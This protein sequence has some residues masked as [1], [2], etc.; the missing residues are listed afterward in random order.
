MH[1]I[2]CPLSQSLSK[3]TCY[4]KPEILA[5]FNMSKLT[6]LNASE[7]DRYRLIHS[8]V[9]VFKGHRTDWEPCTP[10]ALIELFRVSSRI[11]DHFGEDGEIHQLLTHLGQI[12]WSL[13]ERGYKSYIVT[14]LW[15]P[16]SSIFHSD[17]NNKAHSLCF[18]WCCTAFKEKKP[19]IKQLQLTHCKNWQFQIG[20]DFRFRFRC[21]L[22]IGMQWK[23][24]NYFHNS[25]KK[26]LYRAFHS[27]NFHLPSLFYTTVS[28]CYLEKMQNNKLVCCFSTSIPLNFLRFLYFKGKCTKPRP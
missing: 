25:R 12:P 15:P 1:R 22:D 9:T 20:F 4:V 10:T 11:T 24:W 3:M 17:H 16:L 21:Y 23:S 5:Y 2:L 19:L 18:R 13:P 26:M 27:S 8:P 7:Y 14:T 6:S 28:F